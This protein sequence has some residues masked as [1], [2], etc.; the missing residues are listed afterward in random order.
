MQ[1]VYYITPL[2]AEDLEL[3]KENFEDYEI[4]PAKVDFELI[5]KHKIVTKENKDDAQGV[6]IVCKQT[7]II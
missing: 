1:T 5:C 7:L 3:I 4:Q 2:S 6:C